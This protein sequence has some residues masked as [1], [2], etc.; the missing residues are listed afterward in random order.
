MINQG[1]LIRKLNSLLETKEDKID[2][3]IAIIKHIQDELKLCIPT[4]ENP[5][6]IVEQQQIIK[7]IIDWIDVLLDENRQY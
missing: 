5:V 2:I 4:K 6:D 1:E 3:L 7:E